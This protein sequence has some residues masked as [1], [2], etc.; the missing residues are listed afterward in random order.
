M[1]E[2]NIQNNYQGV[3]VVAQ[4]V[5]NPTSVQEDEVR[6]RASLNGLRIRCCHKLW[7]RSWMRLGSGIAMCCSV[8]W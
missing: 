3:P 2:N 1:K 4:P 7:P 8:G 5:K 6:P